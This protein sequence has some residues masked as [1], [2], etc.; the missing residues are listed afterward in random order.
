MFVGVKVSESGMEGSVKN[1]EV[2]EA[3]K[4]MMGRE[5]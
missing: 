1:E 3:V 2:F 5:F 4:K